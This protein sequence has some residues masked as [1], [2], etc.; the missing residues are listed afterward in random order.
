MLDLHA[1]VH[2]HV[3]AGGGGRF[4]CFLIDDAEFLRLAYRFAGEPVETAEMLERAAAEGP[5]ASAGSGA[6]GGQPKTAVDPLTG[7]L[8]PGKIDV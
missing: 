6:A 8:R 7:E 2:H 1:A 4:R 3:E 5:R